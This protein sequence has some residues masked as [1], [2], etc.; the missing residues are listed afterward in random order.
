MIDNNL[1]E[2]FKIKPEEVSEIQ[3]LLMTSI[4]NEN[5]E[6]INEKYDPVVIEHLANDLVERGKLVRVQRFSMTSLE[7]TYGL[8]K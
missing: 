8:P 4:R 6:E 2:Q 1:L 7:F 5:F 3:E